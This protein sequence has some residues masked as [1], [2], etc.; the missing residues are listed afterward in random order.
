MIYL[1]QIDADKAAIAYLM[2]R[3]RIAYQ[4][5]RQVRIEWK[6]HEQDGRTGLLWIHGQLA[7]VTVVA[8][9]DFNRSV[10]ETHDTLG[11]E[12]LVSKTRNQVHEQYKDEM[13]WD[14]GVVK[15]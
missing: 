3:A 8:R 7:A 11:F 12:H 13:R 14:N 1:D 5:T 4:N 9:D 10:L 2:A 15:T 6:S